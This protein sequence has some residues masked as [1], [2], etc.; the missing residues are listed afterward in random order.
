MADTRRILLIEGHPDTVRQ[1]LN[2]ALVDA[3]AK[4]AQAAGC[5]V[6]RLRVRAFSA[7]M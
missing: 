1:H 7:S 6:R 3:Y 5:A 2:R 4:G